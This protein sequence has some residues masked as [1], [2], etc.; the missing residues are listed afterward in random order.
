[1][2]PTGEDF[3]NETL[4]IKLQFQRGEK[5][6]QLEKLDMR[7]LRWYNSLVVCL[8]TLQSW[9]LSF[10]CYHIYE[11]FVPVQRI[12]GGGVWEEDVEGTN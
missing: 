9:I 5:K 4:S 3:N 1:M 12:F 10:F 11:T 2:G 8:I 7:L 6:K